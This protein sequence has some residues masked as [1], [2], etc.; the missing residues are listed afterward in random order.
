MIRL[1]LVL[2]LIAAPAFAQQYPYGTCCYGAGSNPGGWHG[3][4]ESQGDMSVSHFRNGY[5]QTQD[6][7]TQSQGRLSQTSCR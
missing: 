7:V 3:Y 2:T 1:A 4:T 5:G 6:C